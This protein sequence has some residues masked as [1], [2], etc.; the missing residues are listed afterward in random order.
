VK[1]ENEEEEPAHDWSG[2]ESDEETREERMGLMQLPR[3]KRIKTEK[4]DVNEYGEDVS[5]G[6]QD[7]VAEGNDLDPPSSVPVHEWQT[8]VKEFF[9]AGHKLSAGKE[10]RVPI[11][12]LHYTTDKMDVKGGTVNDKLRIFDA[13]DQI[14]RG[15]APA[16]PL[17]IVVS[18]DGKLWCLHNKWLAA[19]RMAQM[20]KA[21]TITALCVVRDRGDPTIVA[22]GNTNSPHYGR[23]LEF[24]ACNKTSRAPWGS[25]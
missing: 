1:Q 21:T 13:V 23:G 3:L 24:E 8:D 9:D 12:C 14:F 5:P 22:T 10:V 15:E 4:R 11:M 18:P 16:L 17:D 25:D 6:V 2:E 7:A 20:L 19:L